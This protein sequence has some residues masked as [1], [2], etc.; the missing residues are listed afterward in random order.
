MSQYLSKKS[1]LV[2]LFARFP[3]S[4]I[5]LVLLLVVAWINPETIENFQPGFIASLPILYAAEFIF[6]HASIGFCLPVFFT[7]VLRWIAG[8]FIIL[9]YSGFFFVL[10]KMGH[11]IQMALFL[12]ITISRVYRAENNFLKNKKYDRPVL[13]SHLAIPLVFRL[14][15]LV[16]CTLLTIVVPLPQLGL[17][18]YFGPTLGSGE[19]VDHPENVIFV[20]ILYFSLIPWF[21]MKIFPAIQKKIES[22]L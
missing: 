7:G 21:E 5:S 13:Y 10:F 11:Q 6:G 12:W 14:T 22:R 19:F 16:I 1:I 9:L 17:S 2:N 18:Q 4:E 15:F 3:L 20:L 8:L